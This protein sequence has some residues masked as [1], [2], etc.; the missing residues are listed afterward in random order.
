MEERRKILM[1]EVETQH[2]KFENELRRKKMKTFNQMIKT[3][4]VAA[5]AISLTACSATAGAD[6]SATTTTG[7]DSEYAY[8]L[9]SSDLKKPELDLSNADGKLAEILKNGVLKIATSPDYPPNEYVD[10]QGVVWGCELQLAK[11]VADSLG[12]DLDIETMDFSGTLVAIDTGKVDMSFSGY[13]WK[14]DRADAYELSNGYVGDPNSTESS[15]HT[16]ITTAANE[17][18]FKTLDDFVGTHILAQATSLQEMY[19]QDEIV[20]I[21]TTG[22]TNYEPVATLDQAILGLASGK[23][24]AVALD[25]NTAENYVKSSDGQFVLTNVY[26][27]LT[28]YGD[29][30]GNVAAAKKGETSLI[31]AVNEVIDCAKENGYYEEWY[32]AAKEKA[33]VEE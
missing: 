12:V 23:C 11:Y 4:A 25:N 9:D 32:K 15:K 17:G 14:K 22:T 33:G 26:F 16:L 21:D 24:D 31:N 10:D 3:T 27:D 29:Y 5:L 20:A 7:S 8:L 1:D 30:Q 13:G 28:P 2:R 19:V 18:K 6:T